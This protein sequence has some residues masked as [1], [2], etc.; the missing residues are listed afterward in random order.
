MFAVSDV[1]SSS[2]VINIYYVIYIVGKN[3][4]EILLVTK[5][6]CNILDKSMM[7]QHN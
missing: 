3:Q 4:L 5:A 7:N 6:N 1:M 2:N